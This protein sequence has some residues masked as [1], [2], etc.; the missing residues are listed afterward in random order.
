MSSHIDEKRYSVLVDYL[1][2]CKEDDLR[3]SRVYPVGAT[4]NEQAAMFVLKERLLYY[5]ATDAANGIC[6]KRV[7]ANAR[8]EPRLFMPACHDGVDGCHYGRDKTR[9]KVSDWSQNNVRTP[10]R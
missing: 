3:D 8:R 9:A 5:R 1:I 2:S 7:I 10:L 4:A 6:L